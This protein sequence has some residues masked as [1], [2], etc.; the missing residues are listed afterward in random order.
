MVNILNET[1]N[2]VIILTTPK[3]AD[4]R[5]KLD[6]QMSKLGVEYSY[7]FNRPGNPWAY[8]KWLRPG[9]ISHLLGTIDIL[10]EVQKNKY[11]KT[12]ILEDDILLDV[13][14]FDYNFYEYTRQIPEDWQM[15]YLG[16]NN[17]EVSPTGRKNHLINKNIMSCLWTLTTSAYAIKL[18]IVSKLLN[19]LEGDP[20]KVWIERKDLKQ[21]DMMWAELQNE[22]AIRAY[23]FYPA[24]ITQYTSFSD[25]QESIV[26]YDE[27][28]K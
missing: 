6:A 10:K 19:K 17:Q 9:E 18:E 2:K 1:F 12:L 16:A 26:C 25:I 3:R 4:R 23:S 11:E 13:E 5:E 15:L 28:I 21:T 27:L 20:N 24:L 14:N 7:H 8:H 22:A